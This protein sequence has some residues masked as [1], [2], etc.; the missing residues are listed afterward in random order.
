MFLFRASLIIY[1]DAVSH[2]LMASNE[3]LTLCLLGKWHL[4]LVMAMLEK[5]VL[6]LLEDLAL[7]Y[8]YQ[9]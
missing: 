4:L 2:L 6:S 3:L 1:M 9:K 8:L 7:E 5:D